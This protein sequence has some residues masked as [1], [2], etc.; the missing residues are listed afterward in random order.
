MSLSRRDRRRRQTH[1]EQDDSQSHRPVIDLT[2]HASRIRFRVIPPCRMR[3]PRPP[4]QE[5][6]IALPSI[7]VVREQLKRESASF[8]VPG[9]VAV[10]D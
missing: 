5:T 3:T 2:A 6:P 4:S 7:R 1:G 10:H 9:E 8:R